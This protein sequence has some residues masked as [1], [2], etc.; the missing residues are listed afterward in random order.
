VGEIHN[1]EDAIKEI[2]KLEKAMQQA[3]RD[4]QFEEAA[5]IRDRI[6]NIKESLLFGA[7]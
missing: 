4:L 1:E 2:A 6:R 5:V 7:E 3:A